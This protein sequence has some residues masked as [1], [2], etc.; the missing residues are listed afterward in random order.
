M[1]CA[2]LQRAAARRN[3]ATAAGVDVAERWSVGAGPPRGSGRDGL[4]KL[5][6][7]RTAADRDLG[8]GGVHDLS[9]HGFVSV[10]SK[11]L[12]AAWRARA[13]AGGSPG[14]RRQLGLTQPKASRAV[15]EA[16]TF[17]AH[18]LQPGSEGGARS[19]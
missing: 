2:A 12:V 18:S 7:G 8:A 14:R 6:A 5:D 15:S 9:D 1:R 19:K 16:S 10:A 4:E 11:W 3:P 13:E 17:S